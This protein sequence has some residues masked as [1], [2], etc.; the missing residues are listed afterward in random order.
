MVTC[1]VDRDVSTAFCHSSSGDAVNMA[2]QC[3]LGNKMAAASLKF[4]MPEKR[5]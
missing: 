3:S 4:D 5:V 1:D 2:Q